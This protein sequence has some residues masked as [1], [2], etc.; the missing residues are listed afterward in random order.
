VGRAGVTH[1]QKLTFE[2]LVR[3]CAG[4]AGMELWAG[5]VKRFIMLVRVIRIFRAIRIKIY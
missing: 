5:E 1:D 4:V 2:V 3:V